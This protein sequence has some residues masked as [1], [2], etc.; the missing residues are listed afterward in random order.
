MVQVPRRTGVSGPTLIRL[1]ARLTDADIPESRQSLSDRLSQWLGWTDAIALSAVLDGGP[2]AVAPAPQ[3]PEGAETQEY[4][5]LRAALAHAIADER[6][7]VA[8]PAR[9][10]RGPLGPPAAAVP[11]TVLEYATYRQRYLS[12]QQTMETRIGKLR[13]RLRALLAARAPAL[14]R[15]AMVDAILE[16]SLSLQ[17]RRLLA[18]VPALLEGH[19]K[20]LRQAGQDSQDAGEPAAIPPWLAA[21]RKDMRSVLLAELDIRLQPIEGLL[22]ALRAG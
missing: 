1:L 18:T 19:F 20:R 15:L 22:A 9:G 5:S 14:A 6:A 7:Y 12:L 16:R 4:S 21:F 2:L 3:A 17:E 10:A 8:A 11:D 13:G